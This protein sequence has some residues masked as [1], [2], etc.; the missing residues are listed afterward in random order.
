MIILQRKIDATN[1]KSTGASPWQAGAAMTRARTEIK[2]GSQGDHPLHPLCSGKAGV[3]DAG[4]VHLLRG[5]SLSGASILRQGLLT[6]RETIEWHR[7][8]R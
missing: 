2:D 7:K 3:S 8:P 1:R 6:Q 5:A 4:T